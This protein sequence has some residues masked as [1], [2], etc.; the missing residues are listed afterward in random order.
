MLR[1]APAVDAGIPSPS[2]STV[3]SRFLACPAGD[4]QFQVVVRDIANFTLSG[5]AVMLDFS[6][7]P[8]VVLCD[9]YCSGVTIDWQARTA[10]KA[11]DANGVATFSLKMGGLCPASTLRVS[12]DYVVLAMPVVSS[13]DQDGSLV[14]DA[15]D[16]TTVYGLIGTSNVGADFDGDGTVTD[17]DL[18]WL[19]DLH[20]GHSCV[21]AVPTRTATWGSVKILYR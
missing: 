21:N 16:V 5:S 13:P 9:D 2:N 6:A 8:D 11:T 7:C 15:P 3:P 20:G 14:V 18:S 19:T 4:V 1:L 10:T 12:A 17:A